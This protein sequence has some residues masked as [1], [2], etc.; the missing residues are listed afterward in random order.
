MTHTQTHTTFW[1]VYKKKKKAHLVES[2]ITTSPVPLLFHS[3]RPGL[4]CW[5]TDLEAISSRQS[6]DPRPHK[7]ARG[8][9]VMLRNY[10]FHARSN[11]T[12]SRLT[13]RCSTELVFWRGWE[14]NCI[15]ILLPACLHKIY[16]WRRGNQTTMRKHRQS[17]LLSQTSNRIITPEGWAWKASHETAN[18]ICWDVIIDR[19]LLSA[20]T[21]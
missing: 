12:E 9:Q 1:A 6:P 13:R 21:S 4:P 8:F 17:P 5:D 16:T 20:F 3:L 14:Q 11:L 7:V 15:D 2:L 19:R 10:G 18:S